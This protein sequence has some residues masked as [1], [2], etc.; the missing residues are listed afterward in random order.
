VVLRPRLA[1]GLPL[2]KA[3][4]L[5]IRTGEE[6]IHNGVKLHSTDP[7][8]TANLTSREPDRAVY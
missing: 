8:S 3:S 2:S 5:I 4:A 7:Y 6:K 1:V